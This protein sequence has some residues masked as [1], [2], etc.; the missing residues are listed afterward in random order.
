MKDKKDQRVHIK[1]EQ[2]VTSDLKDNEIIDTKVTGMPYY[3][4]FIHNKNYDDLQATIE[5]ISPCE[6][7][8]MVSEYSLVRGQSFSV[9]QLKE[10]RKSHV[11]S[12]ID[13]KNV[14][15]KLNKKLCIPIL[16]FYHQK[17]EGL[18]RMMVIGNM[19]GWDFKIPVLVV[20]QLSNKND[21]G[22]LA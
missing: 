7:Y 6:Y 3:Q 11:D 17:Q 18:H 4:E 14:I 2:P 20:R 10:S 9:E 8:D 1:E 12:L 21:N 15:I 22:Y 5:L 19:Y 16:D 13:I